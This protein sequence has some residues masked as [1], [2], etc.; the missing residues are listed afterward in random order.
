VVSVLVWFHDFGKP[1]DENNEYE[2]TK[3]VGV[4]TLRKIGFSE[5]FIAKVLNAWII[6]EQKN[7]IDISKQS[8]EVKIISGA[9]G[10][11]HFVGKFYPSYFG[12][13]PKVPLKETLR[14]LKSK[15]QKDWERKIVLP[16]LKEAFKDRYDRAME[17]I[18]IYPEK[19]L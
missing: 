17:I 5:E 3:S 9:D 7:E 11:S 6:M 1:L 18:G 13:V 15:I 14:Q 16:E 4:E 8:I 19:F 12:D 10:A 2:T